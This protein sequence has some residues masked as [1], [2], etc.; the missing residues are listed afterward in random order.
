M[1]HSGLSGRGI[2]TKILGILKFGNSLGKCKEW[3]FRDGIPTFRDAWDRLGMGNLG[4]SG[5]GRILGISHVGEIWELPDLGIPRKNAKNG[6]SGMGFQLFGMFGITWEWG[7]W[8]P[9]EAVFPQKFGEFSSLGI[10]V[11]GNFLGKCNEWEFWDGIPTFLD[12]QNH[13]G[14]WDLGSSG[15]G[16]IFGGI[17]CGEGFGNHQIWDFLRI[18]GI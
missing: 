5:S 6:N 9:L 1:G 12:I 18:F 15:H 2:P 11:F 10:P 14:M 8:K 7:I 16:K 4:L 13:L 17:L 3:E